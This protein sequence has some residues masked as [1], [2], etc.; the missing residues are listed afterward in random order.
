M[1]GSSGEVL[2]HGMNLRMYD[3]LKRV[4]NIKWLNALYGKWMDLTSDEFGGAQIEG[5]SVS[6]IFRE[7]VGVSSGWM[8]PYTNA[9]YTDVSLTLFTWRGE[10]W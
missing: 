1:L 10:K 4:W 5:Q 2:V 3:A 7:P 6:Y 9:T 8:A